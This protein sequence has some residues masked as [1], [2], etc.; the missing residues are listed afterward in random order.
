MRRY[1]LSAEIGAGRVSTVHLA[2]LHGPEK[3]ARTVVVKRLRPQYA[4]DAECVSLLLAGARLAARVRHANVVPALDVV[5]GDE[6][7]VVVEYVHGESLAALLRTQRGRE[8]P[9]PLAVVSGVVG[10]M[11]RGLQAVDAVRSSAVGPAAARRQVIAA[12]DVLVGTDGVARLADL[13]GRPG[14]G[15][16]GLEAEDR[17]DLFGASVILWEALAGRPFLPRTPE[18]FEPP[19]RYRPGLDAAID[20]IV[21][22]G[23][24]TGTEPQFAG[25]GAMAAA[26]DAA[27]PPATPA[28]VGAWVASLAREALEERERLLAKVEDM[29]GRAPSVRPPAD[30]IPADTSVD[31]TPP[32]MSEPPPA[33]EPALPPAV[34]TRR[35]RS[36]PPPRFETRRGLGPVAASQDEEPSVRAFIGPPSGKR[37]AILAAGIAGAALLVA[38][39]ARLVP[40]DRT[41]PP[42]AAVP[43]VLAPP[44]PTAPIPPPRDLSAIAAAPPAPIAAPDEPHAVRTPAASA[45]P[46][47]PAAIAAPAAKRKPRSRD[48][49]L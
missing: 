25:A 23:L 26:L 19:S 9:A 45:P 7:L 18:G 13:A 35:M 27:L 5:T 10:G 46:A 30:T 39:G 41:P 20:A 44:A 33:L 2:R 48:D 34:I 3:F 4:K 38:L 16:A 6:V 43:A 1:A 11:L 29:T 32:A 21:A 12:Q 49:V 22:K 17:P 40:G 47:H 36:V 28:Q 8:E 14:P 31:T 24:A 15:P 42:E 37:R